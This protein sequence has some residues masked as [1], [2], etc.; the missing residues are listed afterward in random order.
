MTALKQVTA[1]QRQAQ[2]GWLLAICTRCG[3]PRY[4]HVNHPDEGTDSL[5]TRCVVIEN[6]SSVRFTQWYFYDHALAETA[7]G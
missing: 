7:H 5:R 6:N 3:R 4:D 1:D 2:V